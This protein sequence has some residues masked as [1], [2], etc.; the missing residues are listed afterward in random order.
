M[1][2]DDENNG[3]ILGKTQFEISSFVGKQNEEMHMELTKGVV[4]GAKINFLMDIAIPNEIKDSV[5]GIN[6]K[7]EKKEEIKEEDMD[8]RESY[9]ADQ[10]RS[11]ESS[12]YFTSQSMTE[13]TNDATL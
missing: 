5:P 11:T 12:I 2:I 4:T 1:G 9:T 3:Y 8:K 7:D 10:M 6:K 13:D